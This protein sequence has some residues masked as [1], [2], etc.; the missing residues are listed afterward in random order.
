MPIHT[1]EQ[2]NRGQCLSAIL[3]TPVLDVVLG[4]RQAA[5]STAG[6][7]A[8]GWEQHQPTRDAHGGWSQ[9]NRLAG[10][11]LEGVV[12]CRP[13]RVKE[14]TDC[15]F[16]HLQSSCRETRVLL[17]LYLVQGLSCEAL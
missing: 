8:L 5:G 15:L 4:R 7:Q 13:S 12:S 16:K 17:M 11:L 3:N 14:L 1:V 6:A 10:T 2:M 9:V